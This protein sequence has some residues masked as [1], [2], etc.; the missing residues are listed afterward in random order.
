MIRLADRKFEPVAELTKFEKA[1]IGAG[2]I[3]SFVGK[4]R[5]EADGK[6]VKA[7]HLDHY[8]GV[9]EQSINDIAQQASA[10]W[11][12]DDALII[13]RTGEVLAGE[14]IVLVCVASAH[15]RPAFEAAD[16]LMDYL[17]TEALFWKK[18]RLE[19]QERWIEPRED[20]YNDA[21]RWR[22]E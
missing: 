14:P 5:G 20:D 15:R 9:T 22:K 11:A 16:F 3:V 21:A 1:N 6:K 13:H 8:P 18:E 12:I 10:R 19:G 17:K 4:V 2:A 7:L